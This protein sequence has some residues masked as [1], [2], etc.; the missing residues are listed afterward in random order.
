MQIYRPEYIF[1][2]NHVIK[3]IEQ[4]ANFIYQKASHFKFQ[5]HIMP[6]NL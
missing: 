2:K 6:R 3:L 4:L 5:I 1:R